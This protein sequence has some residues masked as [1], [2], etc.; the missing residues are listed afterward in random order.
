MTIFN[1]AAF[2][3]ILKDTGELK[4]HID[5]PYIVSGGE[6]FSDEDELREYLQ[7]RIGESEVIYYTSAMRFLMEYDPSLNDS[8]ELA[9]DMGY[10]LDKLNSE[11]L[12][13]LLLQQKL[14]E[15]LAELDLAPCFIGAT[16]AA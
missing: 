14:S 5:T 8:L 1:A 4:D 12:A 15:E 2:D 13:T 3:A 16:E 6:S 7:E 9:K 11:I 10:T